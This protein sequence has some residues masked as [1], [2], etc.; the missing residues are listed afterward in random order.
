MPNYSSPSPFTCGARLASAHS[1]V[2][3][4]LHRLWAGKIDLAATGKA[5]PSVERDVGVDGTRAR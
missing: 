2:C 1:L 5:G 4:T 3:V